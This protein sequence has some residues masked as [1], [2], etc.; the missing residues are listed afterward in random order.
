MNAKTMSSGENNFNIRIN[1]QGQE[2]IFDYWRKKFVVLTPEEWV[3]QQFLA[4]L[5]Y[6]KGYPRSLMAVEKAVTVNKMA[7]RFDAVVYDNSGKPVMLLEFKSPKVALS[8]K[9][10]EQAARYNMQLKVDYLV[11]CNGLQ[12]YCCRLDHQTQTFKFLSQIPTFSELNLK[13]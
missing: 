1:G 7:K 8:Q 2:E 5:F 10:M 4:F 13:P 12:Q 3:R 6:E 9:T 11:I